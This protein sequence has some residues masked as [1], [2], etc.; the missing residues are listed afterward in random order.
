MTLL[1]AAEGAPRLMSPSRRQFFVGCGIRV[2]V[3][4][5][6]R[7]FQ[8]LEIDAIERLGSSKRDSALEGRG[9]AELCAL[10][11]LR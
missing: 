11:P 6:K 10:A 4:F 5:R 7:G 8:R 1:H 3:P 9:I 2:A